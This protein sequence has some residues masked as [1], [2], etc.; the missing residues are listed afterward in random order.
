M[1]RRRADDDDR[2]RAD[3]D[4]HVEH[5]V[6]DHLVEHDVIDLLDDLALD[7]EHG[8]REHRGDHH[9]SRVR[10]GE[11][12]QREERQAAEARLTGGVVRAGLRGRPLALRLAA[13]FLSGTKNAR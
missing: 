2:D 6:L 10:P 3:L 11:T 7:D 12:R 1:W 8:H 9:D 13:Y 4:D 5:L